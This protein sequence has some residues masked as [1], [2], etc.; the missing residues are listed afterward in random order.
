MNRISR[1]SR[2]PHSCTA[3]FTLSGVVTVT[4]LIATRFFPTV[5]LAVQ[6]ITGPLQ[7]AVQVFHHG[8]AVLTDRVYDGRRRAQACNERVCL[9]GSQSIAGCIETIRPF[10]QPIV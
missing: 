1:P 8:W 6:V 4:V 5:S 10:F 9:G 2:V 7:R 3:T